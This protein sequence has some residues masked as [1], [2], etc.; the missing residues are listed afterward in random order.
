M[1]IFIDWKNIANEEDF[2][3]SL[4]PQ[5]DAP[6]WHGRNLDALSDTLVGG[7]INGIEP[8]MCIINLNVESLAVQL[9]GFFTKVAKIYGE[10]NEHG[11]KIR[12]FE[13]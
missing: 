8:P 1:K 5:L 11:R 13:E 12:V 10:A 6:E 7:E 4:L 2:Y 3:N 9:R